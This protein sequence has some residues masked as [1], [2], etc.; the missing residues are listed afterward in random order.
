MAKPPTNAQ[1]QEQLE[2]VSKERDKAIDVAATQGERADKA[3]DRLGDEIARRKE[4]EGEAKRLAEE[5]RGLSGSLRAY[6]GS[7]TKARDQV[8]V[9][10]ANLSPEARPIGRLPKPKSDA[11]A[12]NRRERLSVAMRA[13][14]TQLV[15][16]D[17]KRE[18]RELAPL[19]IGM[20]AWWRTGRG[21]TLNAEPILEP[22][23]TTKA[24]FELAGFGL[25][26]GAG[27]QIGWC[28]LLEPIVVPSNSKVQIPRGSI[29]F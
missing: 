1:L 14:P 7:A 9:L 6:K 19:I 15:F 17:G 25:L 26:D 20:D 21:E 5:N 16:S 18:I 29:V 10:K 27:E 24:H 23:P 4:A 28:E 2:T 12:A 8:L 11:E 3:E 13:G 22:G